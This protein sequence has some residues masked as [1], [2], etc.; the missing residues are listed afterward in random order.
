MEAARGAAF[1][2]S[3]KSGLFY[4]RVRRVTQGKTLKMGEKH[5][6]FKGNSNFT[7]FI[8]TALPQIPA[9]LSVLCVLCGEKTPLLQDPKFSFS[10][11]AS[12]APW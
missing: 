1:L 11:P 3:V 2:F 5:N 6:S 4:R 9:F 7:A 12:V 10:P 8:G